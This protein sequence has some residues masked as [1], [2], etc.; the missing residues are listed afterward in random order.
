MLENQLQTGDDSWGEV[1][2][3]DE[4]KRARE[5]ENKNEAHDVPK[6]WCQINQHLCDITS[7]FVLKL[8]GFTFTLKQYV[9]VAFETLEILLCFPSLYAPVKL[10]FGCLPLDDDV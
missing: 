10:H 1:S 7:W 8:P 4:R 9:R 3:Y 5:N 2:V 6:G